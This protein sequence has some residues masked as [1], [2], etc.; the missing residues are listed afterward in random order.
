MCQLLCGIAA[1]DQVVAAGDK[2]CSLGSQ[3]KDQ[4]GYI[5]ARARRFAGCR[6]AIACMVASSTVE[7]ST[8]VAI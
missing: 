5:L 2:R 3:D 7:V 6:L 8:G 4:C 1:V